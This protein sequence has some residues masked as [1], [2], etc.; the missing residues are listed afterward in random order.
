MDSELERGVD[1]LQGEVI[2]GGRV[3]VSASFGL[4]RD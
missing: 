3:G 1:S 2:S 4:G